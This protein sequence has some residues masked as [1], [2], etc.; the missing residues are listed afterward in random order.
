MAERDKV[1]KSGQLTLPRILFLAVIGGIIVFTVYAGGVYLSIGYWGLTI[2][3]C[4]LLFLIAIDYGV[5]MDKVNLTVEPAQAAVAAAES[6][7]TATP[8]LKTTLGEAR[9]KK[10]TSR[11]AK[12]R[13]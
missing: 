9:P 6:T 12:R 11:P 13:R 2:A 4:A 3:I 10:R 1:I 8:S 7:N 5:K